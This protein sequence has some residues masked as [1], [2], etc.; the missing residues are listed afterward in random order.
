MRT[1][2]ACEQEPINL[3]S[4]SDVNGAS[5]KPSRLSALTY[6]GDRVGIDGCCAAV[7]EDVFIAT[8]ARRGNSSRPFLGTGPGKSNMTPTASPSMHCSRLSSGCHGHR[9]H[10]EDPRTPG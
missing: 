4:A 6:F 8:V 1:D 5:L 3:S 2:S 9:F 7:G 10:E